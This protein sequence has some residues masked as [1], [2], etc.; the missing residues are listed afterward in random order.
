MSPPIASA[1]KLGGRSGN[2]LA[3]MSKAFAKHPVIKVFHTMANA[4]SLYLPSS[5]IFRY[6]LGSLWKLIPHW[7]G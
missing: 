7:C 2:R 5:I 6:F 1:A 3:S 4:E